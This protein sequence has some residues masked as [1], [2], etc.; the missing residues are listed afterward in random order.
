MSLFGKTG[1]VNIKAERIKPSKTANKVTGTVLHEFTLLDFMKT[2]II[3]D[4]LFEK[5]SH[6]KF[7]AIRIFKDMIGS[8]S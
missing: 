2:I 3:F 7:V 5:A 1:E 4:M 6:D 8:G